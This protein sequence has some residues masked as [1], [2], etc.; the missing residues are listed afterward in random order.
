MW[1]TSDVSQAVQ[2]PQR[3]RDFRA[4]PVNVGHYRQQG[5]TALQQADHVGKRRVLASEK[6]RRGRALLVWVKCVRTNLPIDLIA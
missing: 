3:F 5:N 2:R 4:D 1:T 6:H